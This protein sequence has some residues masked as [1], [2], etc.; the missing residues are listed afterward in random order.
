MIPKLYITRTPD[1]SGFPL[2]SYESEFHV[3]LNLM[4]AVSAPIKVNPNERIQVPV[5]FAIGIPKGFCGQV[6]SIPSL[7][8]E[9]GMIVSGAPLILNPVDRDPLFV[10]MQNVSSNPYVLHRGDRIAQLVLTPVVQGYWQEVESEIK[11][12]V[13]DENTLIVDEG[14]QANLNKKGDPFKSF[15]RPKLSLRN[16]YK[17]PSEDEN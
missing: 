7:A 16:R 2:P 15:R 6:V 11:G 13:T 8:E 12:E 14:T 4:A 5:G 10:L 9:H 1:G 3:G 17:N